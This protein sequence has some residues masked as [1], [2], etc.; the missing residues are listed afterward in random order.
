MLDDVAK[1]IERPHQNGT[2][3]SLVRKAAAFAAPSAEP[4]SSDAAWRCC[5]MRSATVLASGPVSPIGPTHIGQPVSQSQPEINALVEASSS[6]CML[7]S[8]ALSPMPPGYA[9]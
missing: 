1:S 6:E 2:S 3:S 8:G 5:S 7:H 9:S 4:S